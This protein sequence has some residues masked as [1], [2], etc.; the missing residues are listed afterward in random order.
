[1]KSENSEGATQAK[2]NLVDLA[3]SERVAKTGSEGI[4]LRE[5]NSINVALSALSQVINALANKQN[6][7]PYRSSVITLLLRESLGGNSKTIMV[8]AV[9]P[10]D[11][12]AL[13]TWSTLRYAQRAKEVQN[14]VKINRAVD[15]KVIIARLRREVVDLKAKLVAA[16]DGKMKSK[17]LR[18]LDHAESEM[19]RCEKP[20][21]E[22]AKDVDQE[23]AENWEIHTLQADEHTPRLVNISQDPIMTGKWVYFLEISEESMLVGTSDDCMIKLPIGACSDIEERHAMIKL[24][25]DSASINA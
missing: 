20:F 18:E 3:G 4:R 2:V 21:E 5:A 13:E 14:K 11:D 6:F 23:L 8:C 19:I 9:S 10:A 25:D 24:T 16:L 17:I 1:V 15:S 7:I 12:N 22:R